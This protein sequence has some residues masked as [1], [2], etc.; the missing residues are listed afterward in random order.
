MGP[1]F[2]YPDVSRDRAL[3]VYC[4]RRFAAFLTSNPCS[5]AVVVL[6]RIYEDNTNRM[7]VEMATEKT[8]DMA[9]VVENEE[10]KKTPRDPVRSQ[11][12]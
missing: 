6:K 3:F 11:Q 4:S 12:A 9:G 7:V 10:E 2:K 8:I 5:S 1:T